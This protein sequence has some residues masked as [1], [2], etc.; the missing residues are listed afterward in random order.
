M[1]YWNQK[2]WNIGMREYWNIGKDIPKH[3]NNGRLVGRT[4]LV[5]LLV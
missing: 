2:N 3:L 4:S 1:E 5:F